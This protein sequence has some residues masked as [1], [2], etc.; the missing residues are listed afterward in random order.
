MSATT[1]DLLKMELMSNNQEYRDLAKE[2]QNY[3]IRVGEL[4]ALLYPS[5]EERLELATIKKKKLQVKDRM[6]SIL[7]NYKRKAASH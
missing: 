6:E 5:E 3:E 4:A 2:H 7:Q 1:G